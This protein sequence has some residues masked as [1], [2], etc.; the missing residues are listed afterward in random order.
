[1]H[2]IRFRF[3][4]FVSDNKIEKRTPKT[5]KFKMLQ[6]QFVEPVHG[7]ALKGAS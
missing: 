1:M 3:L 4:T 6:A 5:T 7:R 2:K